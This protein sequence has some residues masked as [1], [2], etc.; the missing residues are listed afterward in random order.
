[1]RVYSYYPGCSLEGT[2]KEYDISLKA[3]APLL[4]FRLEELHDWS[5]CGSTAAHSTSHRLA[6]A[7]AAR[8][9]NLAAAQANGPDGMVVPCAACYS[10]LK[11]ASSEL[12]KDAKLRA[13]TEHAMG[14][15]WQGGAIRA[16]ALPEILARDIGYEAISS[17]TV[18]SL[19]GL[20]VANYY[21][22]LLV[23]PPELTGFDDPEDPQ[24]MDE[25][26]RAIGAEPVDWSHKVDCCGGGLSISRKE[27][28]GKLVAD[29]IDAAEAA[30]AD[31]IV[32]ACPMCHANLDTRQNLAE[33]VLGRRLNMP[34]LYITQLLGL[35]LGVPAGRLAF[36]SHL[37][38]VSSLLAR[39]Q[40]GN[41]A[42]AAG[43]GGI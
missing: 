4:G 24:T 26:C 12:G 42:Q 39:I 25:V 18:D 27:L 1:V 11:I 28:V 23:R 9:L 43:E 33:K 40:A 36:K 22:C 29:I 6:V 34:I 35:A 16:K 20:K 19:R 30:G 2:A 3:V 31:C 13:E 38:S 7:L 17:A 14:E 32:T 15:A 10:R 37:T 8:N 5:C 21:G 41:Q